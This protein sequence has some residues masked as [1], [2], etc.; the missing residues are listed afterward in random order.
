MCDLFENHLILGQIAISLE[1]P[2][3]E[4]YIFKWLLF[5]TF[6]IHVIDEIC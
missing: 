2:F 6:Y 4:K 3:A 5:F 1:V